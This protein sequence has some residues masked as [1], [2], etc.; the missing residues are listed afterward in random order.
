MIKDIKII[1]LIL[2]ILKIFYILINFK[3]KKR[4]NNKTRK[5]LK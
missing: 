1:N 2:I 5:T 3:T 4:N